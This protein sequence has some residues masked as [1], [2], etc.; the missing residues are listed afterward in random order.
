MFTFIPDWT[1]Y[2]NKNVQYRQNCKTHCV[3]W[4]PPFSNIFSLSMSIMFSDGLTACAHNG[5]VQALRPMSLQGV[6]ISYGVNEAELNSIRSTGVFRCE[7]PGMYMVSLTVKS[8][9]AES[10]FSIYK[11]EQYLI[12]VYIHDSFSTHGHLTFPTASGNTVVYLKKGD[13]IK[14]IPRQN[15]QV[16]GLKG[17]SNSDFH[18]TCIS[19][20]KV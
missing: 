2:V 19:I 3:I 20:V 11:N 12:D 9:G 1:T 4:K 8:T 15:A 14:V 13:E 16:F 5:Q 10:W 7:K 17:D 18:D 6:V